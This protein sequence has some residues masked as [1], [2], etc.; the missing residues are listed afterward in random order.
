MKL[1]KCRVGMKVVFNNFGPLVI[2][3]A[4][5]E[6]AIRLYLLISCINK[7]TVNL[8]F[9]YICYMFVKPKQLKRIKD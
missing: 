1:K 9:G 5:R 4:Y 2:S 3:L 8:R 7:R 6:F